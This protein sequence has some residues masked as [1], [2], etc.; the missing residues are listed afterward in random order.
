MITNK[1]IFRI[2]RTPENIFLQL[3]A[4]KP[5]HY[6]SSFFCPGITIYPT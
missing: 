5:A 3:P 4:R 2:N 1:K 6:Y